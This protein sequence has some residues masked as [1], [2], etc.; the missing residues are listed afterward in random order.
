MIDLSLQKHRSV[1]SGVQ[2]TGARLE[3]HAC[4]SCMLVEWHATTLADVV[5]DGVEV[6]VIDGS[7]SAEERSPP[8][9]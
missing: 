3:A 5:V 2:A 6:I 8:Y 7:T 4:R 1:W 9:R